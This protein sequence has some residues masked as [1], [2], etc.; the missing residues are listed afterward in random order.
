MCLFSDTAYPFPESSELK[1][2]S[3]VSFTQ[4]SVPYAVRAAW[5]MS[6]PVCSTVYVAAP[7]PQ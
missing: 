4:Y 2:K 7:W 6:T 3:T 5:T 1:P